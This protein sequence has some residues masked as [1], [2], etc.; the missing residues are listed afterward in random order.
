MLDIGVIWMNW[1]I[2]D[3]SQGKAVGMV[4][5]MFELKVWHVKEYKNFPCWRVHC[6]NL[7]KAVA[8]VAF[9]LSSGAATEEEN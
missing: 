5:L 2:R 3:V 7:T 4:I 6:K 8:F 9:M 1:A